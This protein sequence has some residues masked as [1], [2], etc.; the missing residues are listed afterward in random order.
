MKLPLTQIFIKKE[1]EFITHHK[2]FNYCAIFLFSQ[3]AKSVHIV[4]DDFLNPR[5]T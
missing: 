5:A 2:K 1:L 4:L 3:K